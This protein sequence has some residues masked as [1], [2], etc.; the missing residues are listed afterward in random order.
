MGNDLSTLLGPEPGVSVLVTVNEAGKQILSTLP[1]T[2]P[3]VPVSDTVDG[4]V[5]AW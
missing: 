1:G 5:H 3:G 2:E 4:A